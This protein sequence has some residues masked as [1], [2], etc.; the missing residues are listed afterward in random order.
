MPYIG[1]AP[2]QGVID[3]GNIVD[4]SIQTVDIANSAITSSKLAASSVTTTAIASDV[5]TLISQG[6]GP[7][8]TNIQVTNSSY[9]VLDDTAVDT[10]GGYIK[11]TGTN[12]TA[13]CQVLI[14]NVAATSTTFVSSTEVR[15]QVPATAAGTYIVYLVNSDGGVAI[16]VNG[17]TFSAVPSWTTGSTLPNGANNT[18]ISIQLAATLATSYALQS[19]STL[20]AGLTL[21]SSGL[22]SGTVSGLVNPTTYNFT[23]VATDAELQDSPRAFSITITIS[24][25]YYE[26]VTLHL[27]G[28][29]TNL[30]NNNE[31]LDSS[32]ANSGT[33]WTI[34]RNPATGPN[35]PT[36]GTFSPFSQTGWGNY[37]GAASTKIATTSM[38][39]LGSDFTLELWVYPQSFADY[40]TIF[41]NRTS[42][43]DASGLVLGLTSAAKVYFYSNGSFLLTT[44]G[45]ISANTWTHIAL[46]RSGS[47]SGNVKI[48]I[49]G[50]ADV[51]TATYTTSFT[52]TAPSIGDDWN[53]RSNLQYYGYLSNLR[54][55]TGALYTSNFTPS[56]TPLTTSVSTGTVVL[57][58]C[59]SN[60]FRDASASSLTIT[61]T[62]SPSIQAFSPFNPTS[63]WSA[64]TNGG[65][66][67]FDGSGDYLT[68]PVNTAI[69]FGTGDFTVEAW[70]YPTATP[71]D[72]GGPLGGVTGNILFAYQ[73]AGNTW[74][75]GR[76][77]VAWDTL[78]NQAPI[79]NTWQHIA[80]S[81]SGTLLRCFFNGKLVNSATNTNSYILTGGGYVGWNGTT[82]YFTGYM[83]NIR[84]VA[85]ALYT[86]DFTPPTAPLTNIT[87]T[88]LLLNFTN[89]GIYDATSKND[90]ETVD[91]A[92]ISTAIT[93][94]WGSGCMKFDGT[95]DYLKQPGSQLT[96]INGDATIEFW[97]Y[98]N[99]I[100]TSGAFIAGWSEANN[101]GK[102]FIY[103][104][105]NGRI[106]I[107]RNGINEIVTLAG[108]ITT[109]VWT[110][111]A[112]TKSSSTTTIYIN[113]SS[114][115][116]NTTSVWNTSSAMPFYVGGSPYTQSNMYI[117]DLRVTNGVARNITA[118][119]TAA[120]PTL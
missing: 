61:V 41:D 38:T 105:S 12:F 52:R 23:V 17:I 15:A 65:S 101:D 74:G 72:G 86:A 95:G 111:I 109:G 68:I 58:T 21:S 20:P 119:P 117:N 30:A 27:P 110:Y 106:A 67:Y 62:G 55:T 11:I 2:Y 39:Q 70:V 98:W 3:S 5:T 79:L 103:T 46:V 85:N 37:F 91:G 75:F 48:Y 97:A 66:G 9:T 78:F 108:T 47:G 59:Q 1:N 26:L 112:I 73:A 36:Q 96:T 8:I 104:Y 83:T 87:N 115:A 82:G 94:K 40:N 51:T 118:S 56:T 28:N 16:R 77:F 24:D 76:N 84:T 14:N 42:D 100:S 120:F 114:A 32:T 19:G 31:F 116:S 45:T 43:V 49:N 90:L 7:K 60:R 69:N 107:G 22:L 50:V 81:R 99:S 88:S 10:A 64:V 102:T 80:V 44:T 57:L 93:A 92:Q 71:G 89:A 29:G 18:A 113:G 53:T 34:T 4:G 13:G 25:P 33:G 54:A 6:G 35:A 63:S